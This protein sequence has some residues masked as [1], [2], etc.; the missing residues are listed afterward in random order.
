[1][2]GQGAK[3]ALEQAISRSR[4]RRTTKIHALTNAEGRPP[5]FLLS[6]GNT[7]DVVM[8][9]ALVENASAIAR[10]WATKPTT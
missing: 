2:D 1:M 3:G 5:L 6:P 8:A 4:G 9:P 7:H 10:L